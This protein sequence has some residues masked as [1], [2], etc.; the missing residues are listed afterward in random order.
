[1]ESTTCPPFTVCVQQSRCWDADNTSSNTAACFVLSIAMISIGLFFVIF[2]ELCLFTRVKKEMN[3]WM[4]NIKSRKT[5]SDVASDQPKSNMAS[6][7]PKS[8]VASDQM[9]LRRTLVSFQLESARCIESEVL[10]KELDDEKKQTL[11]DPAFITTR[12]TELNFVKDNNDPTVRLPEEYAS[13][14]SPLSNIP[15]SGF[16]F[17]GFMTA[18]KTSVLF[19][20][21]WLSCFGKYTVGWTNA[22]GFT[23]LL[24]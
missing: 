23:L 7:Q 5:K 19:S 21:C 8:N 12:R 3:R 4:K 22:C 13:E 10:L 1:M 14:Y 2:G 9:P 6:D 15:A 17:Q 16:L 11:S 18:I 20:N 24:D